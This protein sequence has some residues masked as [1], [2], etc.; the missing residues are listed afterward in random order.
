MTALQTPFLGTNDTK[1][2]VRPT[3]A[4]TALMRL[5]SKVFAPYSRI[6]IDVDLDDIL[7]I[8]S[9]GRTTSRI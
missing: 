9:R 6:F 3:I 7:N 2:L 5:M 1:H 8:R 4:P